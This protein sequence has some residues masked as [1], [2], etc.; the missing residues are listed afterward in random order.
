MRSGHE[1]SMQY[2]LCPGGTGQDSTSASG[3]VT[4]NYVFASGGIS[5]HIVHSHASA[6]RNFDSLFFMLGWAR[7]GFHK[8]H[9]E[10]RYI[11]LVFLYPVGS[12]GHV[13]HSGASGA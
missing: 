5:G 11:A 1:T 3:H 2:F 4:P 9:A 10:T 12:V 13:V 7:C 8:K 6:T